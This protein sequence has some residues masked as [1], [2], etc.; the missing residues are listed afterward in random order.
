MKKILIILVA[1]LAMGLIFTQA[2]AVHVGSQGTE[3]QTGPVPGAPDLEAAKVTF[4]ATCSQCHALSR[5]LGK[6]KI[7][8]EWTKTVKK[9]SSNNKARFGK[10]IPE[11]DQLNIIAYL[12]KNAGK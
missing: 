9:M 8:E 2:W 4:E 12:L 7:R 11:E 10:E 6:K 3:S 1:A 5:P